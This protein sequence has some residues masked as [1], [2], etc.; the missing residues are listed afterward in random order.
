[1]GSGDFI[2]VRVGI[3]RPPGRMN[4]SD[5]VLGAFSKGEREEIEFSIDKAADAVDYIIANGVEKA[6]NEFNRK[7]AD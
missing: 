5:Y 4:P 6:M 2:R 7:E 3:G 1:M